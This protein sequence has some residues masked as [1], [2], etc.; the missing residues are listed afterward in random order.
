[1][2]YEA[3]DENRTRVFRYR[4][5]C[6]VDVYADTAHLYWQFIGTGWDRPTRHAVITVHLPGHAQNDAAR[7]TECTPDESVVRDVATTPLEPG[8]GPGRVGYRLRAIESW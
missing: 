1:M 4:V 8:E 3:E 2:D 5:A 7:P 6:A